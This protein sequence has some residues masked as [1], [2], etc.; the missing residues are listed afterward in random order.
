MTTYKRFIPTLYL[1]EGLLVRSQKFSTFQ[2]I[3]DPIPTIKRLTD[4]RVDELVLL[5]ISQSTI[6]DSRRTDKWH[7][8]GYSDFSN[9]IRVVSKFSLMPLSVGGGIRCLDDVDSLFLSGA[10]KVILNT[11]IFENP[12]LVRNCVEKYGSQAVI[13]SLDFKRSDDGSFLSFYRNGSTSSGLGIKQSIDLA[14]TLGVGELLINSIDHDGSALGYDPLLLDYFEHNNISRP[15][16]INGGA[17]LP[18]HFNKALALPSIDAASAG[19]IFYFSELSYPR[20]KDSI[21]KISNPSAYSLRS[22]ELSLSPFIK[23]EPIYDSNKVDKLFEKVSTTVDASK[24]K[25]KPNTVKTCTRCLYPSLSASPMQFDS[26]GVCMGCRMSDVKLGFNAEEYNR[27]KELLR[28]DIQSTLEDIYT[29][30]NLLGQHNYDCIVSVSGGKDSY[31]Q[32][33]YVINELNLK[34]LL[35]TYNGNN[36]TD[37]GWRNLMNMRHVFDCDHIIVSPSVSVLKKLNKLAFIAMGDM[38]WHAHVG[39]YTTAPRIAAQQ[40]I[41]F[42]FWGE[43]GYADLC[44]QFSMNDFPEMNYRERLEHAG[45]GFEWNFFVGLDGLSRKDLVPWQYPSDELISSTGLR[46]IYLGHYIP[47]ESNYHL[48]LVVDKYGFEVSDKPFQRTYRVGS[49]LDDMHEN[50][51]HDYLKYVKFGYG[52]CTDHAS[53]D[54]RAGLMSRD[55]GIDLVSNYDHVIP[56]DL[57]RWLDY[58]GMSEADFHRIAD[59]FRDPRVWFLNSSDEWEKLNPFHPSIS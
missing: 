22:S 26:D 32:T 51:I 33:H 56:D 19:N 6:L 39:I 8:I 44:G 28:S 58:V 3:G 30:D 16:I 14:L 23:R 59:H 15:L 38:N 35:V 24:Y 43:H 11:A 7:N 54:I 41:P 21:N 10:D 4:W 9:I 45:R 50:G 25:S 57:Y 55:E 12:H 37:V 31:Y 13:A 48:Q 40:N 29:N 47:W 36:Y 18:D 46:Q 34:P 1:K 53:K 5:N 49:N 20:L 2:A 17:V 42:I 27:R 52:R